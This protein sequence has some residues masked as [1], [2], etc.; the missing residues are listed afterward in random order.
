MGW[1]EL[2]ARPD[3]DRVFKRLK[4]KYTMRRVLQPNAVVVQILHEGELDIPSIKRIIDLF[5]EFVY[6]EFVPNTTYQEQSPSDNYEA[7]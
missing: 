6:V 1:S 5:P 7:K 4:L 2:T 3:V